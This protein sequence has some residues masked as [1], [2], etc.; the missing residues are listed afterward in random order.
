MGFMSCEKTFKDGMSVLEYHK[1]VRQKIAQLLCG[2]HL[3]LKVDTHVTVDKDELFL[4]IE[5]EDDEALRALAAH[6][7]LP[8]AL[9]EEI[10]DNYFENELN[11]SD[12]IQVDEFAG[13]EHKC[14]TIDY[15][16]GQFRGRD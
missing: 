8:M 14:P 3:G 13:L 16:H 11:R 9:K 2:K 15:T 4:K 6:S 7:D 10:Y 12:D 1:A 5:L